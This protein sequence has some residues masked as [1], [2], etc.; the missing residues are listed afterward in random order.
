MIFETQRLYFRK[1]KESDSELFFDLK[2]NP[3][4]MNPLP[5]E[6]LNRK[7]SDAELLMLISLEV[8]GEKN[9]WCVCEKGC[10]DFIGGCGFQKN[11]LYQDE[12]GYQ[13]RE[14]YWGKGYGT[15]IANGLIQYGFSILNSDLITADV[16]AS[17]V[18]SVKILEKYMQLETE[19]FNEKDNCLDRRY[20][21]LRDDWRNNL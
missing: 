6:V 13:L 21:L 1:L 8:S 9:I 14:K 18:P 7:E 17:N 16:E 11:E 15:E 2:S 5:R 3:N 12:I 10:D 4:A 19:F 20:A